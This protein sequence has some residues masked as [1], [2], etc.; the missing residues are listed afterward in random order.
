MP[1]VPADRL[2][3]RSLPGVG[4]RRALGSA[5]TRL[6]LNSARLRAEILKRGIDGQTFARHAGISSA[7]LNHVVNGRPANPR[8]VLAIVGTLA[9]LLVVDGLEELLADSAVGLPRGA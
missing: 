1:L 6:R 5:V 7:T 8:T 3:P 9:R 4:E 2:P